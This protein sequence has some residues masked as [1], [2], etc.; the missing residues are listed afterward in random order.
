MR[1]HGDCQRKCLASHYSGRYT[2]HWKQPY[3]RRG[4][5]GAIY[6]DNR[7]GIT[8]FFVPVQAGP[9]MILMMSFVGWEVWGLPG[10]IASAC[11]TL[12]RS[13]VLSQAAR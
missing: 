8:N 3:Y 13:D 5:E 7:L 12:R 11:A 6:V 10:A 9:N 2:R 4:S 1:S